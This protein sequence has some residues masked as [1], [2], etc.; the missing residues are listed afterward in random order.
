MDLCVEIV[1]ESEIKSEPKSLKC[2]HC[3]KPISKRR[4]KEHEAKCTAANMALPD[5]FRAETVDG[6]LQYFCSCG[7]RGKKYLVL[8]HIIKCQQKRQ[9][10]ASTN[11]S[12]VSASEFQNFQET[13]QIIPV[14]DSE[15]VPVI[16]EPIQTASMTV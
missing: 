12:A 6:R 15:R 11:L 16:V 14:P 4:I 7:H 10:S 2:A 8:K 3:F 13:G 5:G 1:E 9:A